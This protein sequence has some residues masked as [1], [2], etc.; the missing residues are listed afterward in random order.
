MLLTKTQHVLKDTEM[1]AILSN[2]DIPNDDQVDT[3]IKV[4]NTIEGLIK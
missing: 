2:R 1:F 4:T 3:W